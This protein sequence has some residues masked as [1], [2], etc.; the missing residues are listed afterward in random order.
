M[1]QLRVNIGIALNS[2]HFNYRASSPY[3]EQPILVTQFHTKILSIIYL[4]TEYDALTT[5]LKEIMTI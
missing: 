1:I 3:R 4:G 2:G 5:W